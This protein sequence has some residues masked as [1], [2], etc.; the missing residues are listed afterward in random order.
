MRN[1]VRGR[2]HARA[3]MC[4]VQ[5]WKDQAV[6]SFLGRSP[7]VR[8][9]KRHEPGLGGPRDD[10][11][12]RHSPGHFERKYGRRT[13]SS[14]SKALPPLR[15]A[16]SKLADAAQQREARNAEARKNVFLSSRVSAA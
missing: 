3:D 5:E 13:T 16:H 8:Q 2:N 12:P 10:G 6:D 7:V 14:V 1:L 15:Q 4:A 11:V 9:S